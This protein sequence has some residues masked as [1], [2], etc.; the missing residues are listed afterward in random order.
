MQKIS[1]CLLALLASVLSLS[2]YAADIQVES[3]SVRATAPGQQ[4]AM[5]DLSIT[6]KQIALLVGVTTPA[7]QSVELHLMSHENGM[8]KMRAVKEIAL[9]AGRLVNLGAEGYHLMLINLKDAIKEGT[10]VPLKLTLKLE[11]NQTM[12]I[13]TTATVKP[14]IALHDSEHDHLHHH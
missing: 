2:V 12:Q 14:L 13:D 8:M 6:S 1:L 7:A 3:A 9:P 4:T 10:T 11:N 5:G